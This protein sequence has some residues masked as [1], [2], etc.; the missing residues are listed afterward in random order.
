MLATGDTSASAGGDSHVP[1]AQVH[2]RRR[3]FVLVLDPD[4]VDA[5]QPAEP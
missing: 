5:E 1:E 3:E 2:G 4:Q